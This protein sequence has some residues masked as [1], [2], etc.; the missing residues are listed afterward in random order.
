MEGLIEGC[1]A[2]FDEEIEYTQTKCCHKESDY[3]E[4]EINFV[5]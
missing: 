1:A 5:G 3:C 2:F 4:F